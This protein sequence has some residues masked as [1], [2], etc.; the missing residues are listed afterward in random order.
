MDLWVAEQIAKDA[1]KQNRRQ[2]KE[3]ERWRNIAIGGMSILAAII[4]WMGI[5]LFLF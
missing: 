3:V 1:L 2:R 5:A 4:V